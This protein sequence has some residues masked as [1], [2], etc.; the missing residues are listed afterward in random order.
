RFIFLPLYTSA[1]ESVRL[2]VA[3]QAANG[4]VQGYDWQITKMTS[5]QDTGPVLLLQGRLSHQGL[6]GHRLQM[7]QSI[8]PAL[9]DDGILI[10]EMDGTIVWTNESACTQSG[11]LAQNLMGMSIWT[12]L[13]RLGR[14]N[15]DK[16]QEFVL[17]GQTWRGNLAYKNHNGEYDHAE[18]TIKPLIDSQSKADFLIMYKR[19]I[20]QLE[21][22]ARKI[23]KSEKRYYSIFQNAPFAIIELEVPGLRQRSPHE[24]NPADESSAWQLDIVTANQ[25]ALDFLWA[26]SLA[27]MQERHFLDFFQDAAKFLEW[28]DDPELAA[29]EFSQETV[30]INQLGAEGTVLL[31]AYVSE[32]DENTSI[33]V[34]MID[35]T[36]SRLLQ[37][38]IQQAARLATLG[39][40]AA[41]IAH[42]INQ[43]LHVMQIS[44]AM[45]L[46]ELDATADL[47]F[48]RER[49]E[50]MSKMIQ[51]S[52]EIINHLR[53]LG[54]P[55]QEAFNIVQSI[56]PVRAALDL[57]AERFQRG[58]VTVNCALQKVGLQLQASRVGLEQV[59][60]NLLMNAMDAFEA[61]DCDNPCI[62]IHDSADRETNRYRIVFRNNGP[63]IPRL[64][65]Q[66][67]FDPFFTT[68]GKGT[69]LGLSISYRIIK[70]HHGSIKANSN[71]QW[72]T[73]QISLPIRQHADTA[74]YPVQQ[75]NELAAATL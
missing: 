48:I 38:Q 75:G 33:L 10:A 64:Q 1:P 71:Q 57:L 15:V 46:E 7:I 30:I 16:I 29:K 70:D 62:E 22:F 42:E 32:R 2:R 55:A 61:A 12:H 31:S 9:I 47:L 63:P 28:L 58:A 39:E 6:E 14:T 24:S 73:F 11:C 52:S 4:A 59:Y 68:K 53:S 19:D 40:V 60:I 69:G 27:E 8:A 45:I 74:V 54:R 17:G 13:S 49:V 25:A 51:R 44:A 21:A 18:L 56:E 66:Q 41:G 37:A 36:E 67:L 20:N 35:V 50:K 43:P 72:T 26:R 34:S 3:M 5:A 65:L 23:H